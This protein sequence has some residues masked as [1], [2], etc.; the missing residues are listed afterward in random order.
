LIALAILY[1]PVYLSLDFHLFTEKYFEYSENILTRIDNVRNIS[2]QI[3]SSQ[4]LNI[5]GDRVF[6]GLSEY[7]ITFLKK[8]DYCIDKNFKN[9]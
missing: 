9:V 4:E 1:H 6:Q 2:Q 8:T 5:Q 3:S 7:I